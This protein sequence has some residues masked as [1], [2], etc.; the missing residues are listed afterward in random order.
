MDLFE[1]VGQHRNILTSRRCML[2]FQEAHSK[3]LLVLETGSDKMR[4]CG[5][6][7]GCH[8][9]F[10]LWSLISYTATRYLLVLCEANAVADEWISG[11]LV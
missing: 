3:P 5:D 2:A 7:M 10:L 4:H 8:A 9:A 11:K 1:D 6:G